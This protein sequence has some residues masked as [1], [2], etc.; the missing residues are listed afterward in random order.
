MVFELFAERNEILF[1]SLPVPP[2]NGTVL[3]ARKYAGGGRLDSSDSQQVAF[4][5]DRLL[6]QHVTEL[7]T[8]R[9]VQFV[10]LP[11]VLLFQLLNHL[12][13][14]R[15]FLFSVVKRAVDLLA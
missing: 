10:L 5:L 11:Q 13:I 3:A 6:D 15:L 9:L 14:D 8:Q 12:L 1:A 7:L 2:D 4:V